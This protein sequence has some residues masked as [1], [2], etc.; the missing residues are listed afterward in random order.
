MRATCLAACL[1]VFVLLPGVGRA[2]TPEGAAEQEE[3]WTPYPDTGAVVS[4]TPGAADAP[5]EPIGYPRETAASEEELA[6]PEEQ[7]LPRNGAEA[8]A[9][10]GVGTA[11]SELLPPAVEEDSAS[12]P[13]WPVDSA[14]FPAA[15]H[16]LHEAPSARDTSSGPTLL[17]SPHEP[18]YSQRLAPEPLAVPLL[19]SLLDVAGAGV[20]TLGS[21][22]LMDLVSGTRCFRERETLCALNAFVVTFL[23]VSATAPVGVWAVGSMLGGEGKLWAAYMGSALGMGLGLVGTMPTLAFGSGVI[24]AVAGPIGAVLGA[25]IA[26]EVS[27]RL[28]RRQASLSVARSSGVRVT[29]VLGASPRGSLLGGMAGSF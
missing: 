12:A 14:P 5:F 8:S 15:P 18:R 9:P 1:C 23:S 16:A 4:P 10:S 28:S 21:A 25:T 17:P 29:P 13:P 2:R 11:P 7:L 6:R 27:H 20:V 19:R 24:L 3:P 22:V 26:Y